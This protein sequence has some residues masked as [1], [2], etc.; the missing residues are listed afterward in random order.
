MPKKAAELSPLAVS[1]LT[2]PGLHFVGGVAGLAL[3]VLE[4]GGRSW[5]LRVQVG[6]KRRDMG[7]G[8]YPDVTLAD[9]KEAAR[10]AREKV[11][12]GVDP[13]QEAKEARDMLK[14]AQANAVPFKRAAAAYI[15]THEAGW[16]NS[17][18]AQQWKNSLEAHAYPFIGD[19][20]VRDIEL[21]HIMNVL[22]PIWRDK[23]E[24][25]NRV[26]GRIEKILDWSTTKGYRQGLNPA[27]WKGHLANLLPAKN[28]IA[29]EEHHPA[30]AISE[31]GAFMAELRQQHGMGAQA[32]QFAI[33]TAA[34]SGEVRGARWR[35]FDLDNRTWTIP[36]ARMK[37]KNEHRVPL[38]QAAVDILRARLVVPGTDDELPKPRG[39]DLVFP[40]PRGGM[41]SDATLLAVIKRMNAQTERPRWFDPRDGRPVV[42]H[43]FRSTFRDWASERTSYPH[44]MGEMA[45]AHVISDKVEA[46]YRRGDLYAKRHHMMADWA[47]FASKVEK[48]AQVIELRSKQA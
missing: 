21:P 17:K 40:A 10:V 29:K 35:E 30:L 4:S 15:E 45:L 7:L 14:L 3:Q 27:R 46:A 19:M 42:P 12:R 37:A 24:T 6:T 22:E 44:E 34:R 33:L 38:S 5:I 31:L 39:D 41:L 26:R 18:H 1:R 23:T 32:L 28:K 47:E 9:A 2:T 25:A 16:K 11:R 36:A 8:G 48:A 20:L 13:I 43:G